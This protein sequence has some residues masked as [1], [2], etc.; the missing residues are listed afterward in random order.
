VATPLVSPET[1]SL[2]VF[3]RTELTPPSRPAMRHIMTRD[4][5]VILSV[6]YECSAKH[7]HNPNIA[8]V[9]HLINK[10]NLA[11]YPSR[12]GKLNTDRPL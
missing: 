2:P 9:Q 5:I 1:F 11:S 6:N 8:T 7:Q 3:Q 4:N 12:V 10:V